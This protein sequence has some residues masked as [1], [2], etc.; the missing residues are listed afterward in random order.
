MMRLRGRRLAVAIGAMG[1]M[2]GAIA[3]PAARSQ[4]PAFMTDP[5]S[6]E[7]DTALLSPEVVLQADGPIMRHDTISQQDITA[8]SLWWAN[9]QFGGKL[10][11]SWLAYS[12]TDGNLRRVD[13]VVNQQVWSLYTYFERY[14]FVTQMGTAAWDYR[15]NMRIFNRDRELLA[16]YMCEP[17]TVASIVDTQP[18]S[19]PP[20]EVTFYV[21]ESLETVISQPQT[22]APRR[23]DYCREDEASGGAARDPNPF[24]EP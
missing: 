3:A 12:G 8:P 5:L 4:E 6:V 1:M 2:L 9:E 7:L 15:Y 14:G 17:G 21:C 13:M 20:C 22:D 16:A 11:N 23:I 18:A 24:G 10:V 19:S